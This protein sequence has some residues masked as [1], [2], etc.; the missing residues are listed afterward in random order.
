MDFHVNHPALLEKAVGI[1][2]KVSLT[3]LEQH[4]FTMLRVT[5]VS[6]RCKKFATHI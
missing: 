2:L 4:S 3:Q 5:A 1:W 6:C